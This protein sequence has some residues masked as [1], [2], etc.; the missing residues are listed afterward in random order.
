MSSISVR[1]CLKHHRLGGTNSTA[2]YEVTGITL[3]V[4]LIENA[5][6]CF[7]EQGV[8]F[9]GHILSADAESGL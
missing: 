7:G 9:L 4:V 6:C 1:Y 5:K 2:L 8:P 3:F